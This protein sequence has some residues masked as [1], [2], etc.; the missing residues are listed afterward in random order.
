MRGP[1]LILGALL[2]CSLSCGDELNLGDE[3]P[4]S[5]S[6]GGWP[7]QNEDRT[8]T[9]SGPGGDL[10]G[11]CAS[12]EPARMILSP[13]SPTGVVSGDFNNDG[14]ADL[15][16]AADDLGLFLGSGDGTFAADVRHPTDDRVEGIA[17]GD[18]NRDGNLDLMIGQGR[19]PMVLLGQGDGSFKSGA[20]FETNEGSVID[21][22]LFDLNADGLLDAVVVSNFA[23]VFHVAL[24][25]GEA[26]AAPRPYPI[27]GRAERVQVED[28]NNDGAVDLLLGGGDGSLNV[29]LGDGQG[30]FERQAGQV[31]GNSITSITFEDLDSDGRTDLLTTDDR[32]PSHVRL[33]RG[34]GNGSFEAG[35]ALETESGPL[36]LTMLDLDRDGTRDIAAVSRDALSLFQ[37]QGGFQFGE[38]VCWRMSGGPS[39]M[40]VDDFNGDGQPDLVFTLEY[41]DQIAILTRGCQ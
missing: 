38:P 5:G 16:V 28:V 36:S 19:G 3:R 13:R 9:V 1:K 21:V 18:I 32:Y 11:G 10:I 25:E 4:D 24:G 15:A 7:F 20:S 8:N 2:L 34:L 12:C 22:A 23:S 33:G 37:G 30:L 27:S 35:P 41:S 29:L 14:N 39:A 40:A 17:K 31:F 26:F 6:S